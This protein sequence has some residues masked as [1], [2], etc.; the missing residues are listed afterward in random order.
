M[1]P[2][3]S[4]RTSTIG[5]V[6]QLA[7]E[8]F[9]ERLRW[10]RRPAA[11]DDFSGPLERMSFGCV[12]ADPDNDI[13]MEWACGC[14]TGRLQRVAHGCGQIVGMVVDRHENFLREEWPSDSKA[15]SACEAALP[16][17]SRHGN[18]ATAAAVPLS[19]FETSP[20]STN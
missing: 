1:R 2:Y 8:F 12:V 4:Q 15:L 7:P 14:G 19:G 20:G 3:L 6:A 13:S 9:P 11:S 16:D 10:P 17:H 5:G 18:A